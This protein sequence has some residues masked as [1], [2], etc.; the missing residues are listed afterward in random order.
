[1]VAVLA[2]VFTRDITSSCRKL[3]YIKVREVEYD[4]GGGYQA[5]KEVSRV[6]EE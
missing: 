5:S 2:N 3:I 1:M 6:P 4:H